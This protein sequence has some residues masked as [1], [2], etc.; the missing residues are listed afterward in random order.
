M[1]AF[2]R[3]PVTTIGQGG[4]LVLL[5]R[6]ARH[7]K[8]ASA[9]LGLRARREES[10]EAEPGHA[11]VE[12]RDTFDG[13]ADGTLGAAGVDF[14]R[15]VSGPCRVRTIAVVPKEE[16]GA[17][18]LEVTAAFN[19]PVMEADGFSEGAPNSFD[20]AICPGMAGQRESVGD[21]VCG[22]EE[23]EGLG[24]EVGSAIGDEPLG[25][26]LELNGMFESANDAGGGGPGQHFQGDEATS[27]VVDGAKNPDRN[28]AKDPDDG[29]VDTP[30]LARTGDSDL[31]KV[32][33]FAENP[34]AQVVAAND[35][36][37]HRFTGR[38]PSEEALDEPAEL[39]GAE[40]GE[41][42]VK[43]NDIFLLFVGG[44][45]PGNGS[46]ATTEGGKRE[47][48]HLSEPKVA[49]ALNGASPLPQGLWDVPFRVMDR[50]G[51]AEENGDD[52][53]AGGG[54]GQERKGTKAAR[55]AAVLSR[56]VLPASSWQRGPAHQ[57]GGA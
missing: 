18:A 4:A 3:R 21:V 35:D 27:L 1:S 7:W 15:R 45:V 24:A 29:E 13:W 12:V 17:D 43:A 16:V 6:A 22:E 56:D 47:F 8:R 2:S 40:V 19:E 36:L 41:V 53:V 14:V 46:A 31:A 9:G 49:D 23:G 38:E 28:D 11:A 54:E 37:A 30:E 55:H 26:A 39:A 52:G 42:E 51:H 25:S 34:D 20:P 57:G 32:A 50:E 33:A 48:S 5:D 10:P 44:A